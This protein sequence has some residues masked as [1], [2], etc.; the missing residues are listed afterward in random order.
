LAI[1]PLNF[2]LYNSKSSNLAEHTL[3][4]SYLHL[5]INFPL[6]F[7]FI[8]LIFYSKLISL[9]QSPLEFVRLSV[10]CF[11]SGI[12][13]LSIVPH[14]E[15]RFLLPMSVIVALSLCQINL[16][17]DYPRL[18][19]FHVVVSILAAIM[20]AVIHQGGVLHATMN[21]SQ[22]QPVLFYHTYMP[23]GYLNANA[24]II[25]LKGGKIDEI[26]SHLSEHKLVSV[27]HPCNVH[28][29]LSGY[30]LESYEEI[31]PNF[32]GEQFPKS[33]FEMCL[34]RSNMYYDMQGS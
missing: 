22:N 18:W 13:L 7:G 20:F 17:T 2:L 1:T 19:R 28:L 12:L 15:A 21:A 31:F 33:I 14:Q 27:I 9:V 32:S 29:N 24:K 16:P 23:P 8:G 3:H 11:F 10:Y 26:K 25:D 30:R 34:K 4:P 6:L 5:L